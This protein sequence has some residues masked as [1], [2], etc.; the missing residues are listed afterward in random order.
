MMDKQVEKLE[1]G[2]GGQYLWQGFGA[3]RI[4]ILKSIDFINIFHI[5]CGKFPAPDRVKEVIW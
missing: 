5:F 4:F 1:L 2:L 3:D